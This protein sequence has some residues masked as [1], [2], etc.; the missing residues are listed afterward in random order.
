MEWNQLLNTRRLGNRQA[1]EEV[2]RSP[3]NSDHDKIIF[4]G[5]FRRLAKKTQ[6]HPLVTNDHIHNRLTHSLEV[7]CVGR[8]LGIKVGHALMDR[9]RLPKGFLPTDLGDIVQSACLAHDIGNPPFGHTGEEAIRNWFSHDGKNHLSGL[10]P[11]EKS[12]LLCFEGN[13]QGLRILTT[14]E[15]H[16]YEGGMRLT[17]STLASFIKYPWTSLPTTKNERPRANKYGV[18]QSEL[19]I[20]HEIATKVGLDQKGEDWYCRHPLVYLMEAAD[21]F[22][23]GILDL[24]DGLEM[25]IL[26]WEEVFDILRPALEAVGVTD[27]IAE[28]DKVPTNRKPSIIR[29]KIISAYIDAAA[30]AFI[31]HEEDIFQGMPGDLISLCPKHIEKSVQDAKNIAKNKIFSHPKKVELEIGAYYIIST[32]LDVMCTAA[33]EWISNPKDMSFKSKRVVDLIGAETFDPRIK[34][35]EQLNTPKYL[36]MMRVIDFVSGMTD[37]YATYLAK[38]FNGMG[39]SR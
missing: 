15:Y 8:S 17:Y 37:H 32:L 10:K 27:L 39:E 26:G 38:Q 35:I 36:A 5:A 18:F 33:D 7:A 16:P 22:C 19:N 12:D 30:E 25:N 11:E 13:A 1:K 2:G 4:S 9:K 23:Y 28:L 24:E 3:F 34:N 21:D 20:F 29:G 6:V 14:A 31:K